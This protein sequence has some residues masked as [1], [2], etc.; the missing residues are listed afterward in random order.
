MGAGAGLTDS[1]VRQV[2][3]QAASGFGRRGHRLHRSQGGGAASVGSSHRRSLSVDRKA[4]TR[5]EVSTPTRPS[6]GA[7][8][9]KSHAMRVSGGSDFGSGKFP[10][11]HSGMFSPGGSMPVGVSGLQPTFASHDIG[12]PE[13]HGPGAPLILSDPRGSSSVEPGE[14]YRIASRDDAGSTM[15]PGGRLIAH[16]GAATEVDGPGNGGGSVTSAMASATRVTKL[17]VE[18]ALSKGDPQV[19]RIRAVVMASL[20]AVIAF[21]IA[22]AIAVPAT[23]SGAKRLLLANSLAQRRLYH[24][25]SASNAWYQLISVSIGFT[26]VNDW[27]TLTANLTQNIDRMEAAHRELL[28]VSQTVQGELARLELG[29]VHVVESALYLPE[30]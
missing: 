23:D 9:P 15:Q 19:T 6:V 27:E 29:C 7:G 10:S 5:G 24:S 17:V 30:V 14:I 13:T 8:L 3:V 20:F 28:S 4:Q 26:A 12:E 11:N 22:I 25:D 18:T 2:H 16:D 1:S 21:A